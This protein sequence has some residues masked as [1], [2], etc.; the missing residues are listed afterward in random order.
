[1][2][3]RQLAFQK[4]FGRLAYKPKNKIACT[5]TQARRIDVTQKANK[6]RLLLIFLTSIIQHFG[7]IS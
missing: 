6:C 1:M 3:E 5:V 7:F 2:I 4:L